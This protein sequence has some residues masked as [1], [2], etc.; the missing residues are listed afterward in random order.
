M[1]QPEPQTPAAGGRGARFSGAMDPAAAALNASIDF[2][3][4]LL[5]DDVR[6]SQAHARMLAKVGLISEDDAATIARGLEQAAGEIERGEVVLDAAL[7]DIHMNLEKRLT[8]IVGEPGR[9]LHTGRSRNDQVCTD[10]KLFTLR[11]IAELVAS[12]DRT[13][14]ALV[15]K[16]RAHAHDLMPGYTHLQR[17]QAVT[18]GH[19]LMAY[20]EMLRR[21]RGRLLDAAAR[22]AQCPLGAGALAGSSLPIDR[23][24]TAATLGFSGGPTRNSLDTVSDR[25]FAAEVAF[26]CALMLVHFSRL[27]EELVLWSTTEF[28]FVS[29]GEGHCSG[30]SLMPQKRNPDIAELLRAKPARVIGDLVA[31]LTISKGITLAYNKDLQ[32]SQE[33][34]YDAIETAQLVLAV[35]PRLIADLTFNTEKMGQAA[36]DPALGATDLA[37]YLVRECGV[38]FRRAHEIV[39]AFVRHAESKGVPLRQVPAQELASIAPELTPAALQSLD[40]AQAV[41]ARTLTGGPAPSRVLAEVQVLEQELKTLGFEV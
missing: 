28:G 27:G 29:L 19:H 41:A 24:T 1:K 23:E 39:G 5:W 21:D 10:L 35:A 38:P 33:P 12:I 15:R 36:M 3:R 22:A 4:R 17:A 25:D 8:E 18:L 13:R 31:L 11:S 6:G 34:L 30:S 40:P 37:E 26:A 9:R 2:D 14:L 7:E 16:A 32:E 20:A